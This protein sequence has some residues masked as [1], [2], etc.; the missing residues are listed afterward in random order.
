MERERIRKRGYT[1]ESTGFFKGGDRFLYIPSLK[2]S[3][4]YLKGGRIEESGQR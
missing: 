2:I 4:S 1:R 3:E